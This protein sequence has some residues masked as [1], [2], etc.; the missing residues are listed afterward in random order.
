MKTNVLPFAL[1]ADPPDGQSSF[2]SGYD[3][4]RLRLA[5]P[6][7]LAFFV[8][9]VILPGPHSIPERIKKGLA[10]DERQAL[11]TLPWEG[12]GKFPPSIIFLPDTFANLSLAPARRANLVSNY[13]GRDARTFA[14]VLIRP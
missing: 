11:R 2:V 5:S 1:K 3:N 13:F 14:I 8:A 4:A 12:N 7:R 6:M 9:M 10:W